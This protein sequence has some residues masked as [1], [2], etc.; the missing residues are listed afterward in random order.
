MR[1]RFFGAS[2][3]VTGSQ[4]C[5]E[6]NGRR[7]L[8]DCGMY[9]E[10]AF[11]ERNWDPMPVAPKSIDAVL[12]THAHLD[13]SGLLPR[14]AREKSKAPVFATAA[15]A[16]LAEL[17]LRDSAQIQAE[18]VALKRKRHRRERRKP[19][20]PVVPLFTDADV[21]RTLRRFEPVEY[22]RAVS[23]GDGLEAVFHDAGHILGSAMIE[24]RTGGGPSGRRLVFSGD[25]GQ[26]NKPLV[27]DPSVFDKAD[28]VVMESTYGNRDHQQNGAIAD[29]LAD[30]LNATLGNGGNVVIPTFAIERSQ[31]LLFH[32]SSL[33]FQ[34][35]LAAGVPV[36]LDSPMAVDATDI[37]RR[38]CDCFDAETW[39]RINAGDRPLRFPG[40]TMVRTTEESKRINHLDMPAIIMATSGMCTAGR[41]KHHLQHNIMRPESTVLFVGYQAPGT[42]GRQILDGNPRVRIHGR[43]WPVTA[44]IARIEGFS[45]HADRAALLRWLGYLQSPP[46]RVFL[47]HGEQSAIEALEG[48]IRRQFDWPVS[49]P[50]FEEAF[51][52]D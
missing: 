41:V 38:H 37:F 43:Q 42:L 8:V 35:K 17:V 23:L 27:R 16:D 5:L 14:L 36:F 49:A 18:D 48:R 25:I 9:Q 4:Y 28:Y 1:L 44:R 26:W 39:Q 22:G 31:E 40:L 11:L 52:L 10:R 24:L 50:R 46:K 21:S 33:V 13:H 29:Q 12:L 19:K 6:T 7:I 30:I 20:H 47:T 15:T 51:E 32:L 34:E 3:Q 2:R 45:G